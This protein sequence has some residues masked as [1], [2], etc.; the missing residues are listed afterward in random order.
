MPRAV[1]QAGLHRYRGIR[2]ALR[3]RRSTVGMQ[4]TKLLALA[5]FLVILFHGSVS[6]AA[7][8]IA[9]S[10]GAQPAQLGPGGSAGLLRL[11]GG[12]SF[13]RGGLWGAPAEEKVTADELKKNMQ[14]VLEKHPSGVMGRDLRR[15][16]KDVGP[17]SVIA[18]T[19]LA[20][21]RVQRS[22]PTHTRR[23]RILVL[24]QK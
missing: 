8:H 11:R 19:A 1:H 4:A 15:T 2:G 18:F 7:G 13:G 14:R 24:H 12:S 17:P 22:A 5:T 20:A 23:A 6:R 3:V 10:G 21:P 16:Y 9:S